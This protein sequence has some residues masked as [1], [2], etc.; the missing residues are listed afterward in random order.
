MATYIKGHKNF[1]PDIKPFTPDYKFL[2]A[3]LDATQAKYDA[4]WK[5]QNDLYNKVVYSP[6]TNPNSLEYQRQ[7]AEKLGPSLE[8]ITG[9]D[10][11]LE[12]N[13][14]AAKSAFAPFFED[15]EVVYDM[16]WTGAYN[17]AVNKFSSL[18]SSSNEETRQLANI[19]VGMGKLDIDR[20]K[21][22]EAGRGELRN[23]P[24]PELILD[25][26]LVRN[27]QK[28]LS[29][30]DPGLTISMPVPNL[31]NSGK[32]DASGNPILVEDDQFIITQ[33]NGNL[34]EGAA[35]E[36]I[37]TALYDDPR[38]QKF[39][40]AKSYVQAHNTAA[41]LVESGLAPSEQAGLNMW[42]KEQVSRLEE[43]NLEYQSKKEYDLRKQTQVNV[44]WDNYS[45]NH[46]VVVGSTD[47][48]TM[49]ANLSDAEKIKIDLDRLFKQNQFAQSD[50][51]DEGAL[52]NKAM[53]MLSNYNM[54]KDMRTAAR[55][56]SLREMEIT[57]EVNPYALERLE[58]RNK[59]NLQI[60]KFKLQ[61]IENM[62]RDKKQFEYDKE[63]KS[64]EGGSSGSFTNQQRTGVFNDGN[65]SA[66]F[67][68][69]KDNKLLFTDDPTAYDAFEMDKTKLKLTRERLGM[70]PEMLKNSGLYNVE[71]QVGMYKIPLVTNPNPDNEDDYFI[72]NLDR[73]LDKL[74]NPTVVDELATDNFQYQE[75]IVSLFANLQEY[76]QDPTAAFKANPNNKEPNSEY[77]KITKKLFSSGSSIELPG[78]AT[79]I[80]LNDTAIKLAFEDIYTKGR[81]V[82]SAFNNTAEKDLSK[83]QQNITELLKYNYTVPFNEEDKS[84]MTEED[85]YEANKALVDSKQ[86][87]VNAEPSLWGVQNFNLITTESV[88]KTVEELNFYPIG[89]EYNNTMKTVEAFDD[90]VFKRNLKMIY[91]YYYDNINT[92]RS[93]TNSKTYTNQMAGVFGPASNIRFDKTMSSTVNLNP[94]AG[95]EQD[96]LLGNFYSQ[97]NT[98][99]TSGLAGFI[100]QTTAELDQDDILNISGDALD[101][102][103][104]KSKAAKFIYDRLNTMNAVDK[105]LAME[106]T[107]FNSWGATIVD[108]K[109]RS[110]T[111]TPK[112]AYQ[113]S[114]FSDAFIK[115]ILSDDITVVRP[116][117]VSA[118]EINKVLREGFTY[119]FPR[120]NT[121]NSNPLSYANAASN[122][123]LEKRINNSEN[124]VYTI[125]PNA[126]AAPYFLD[127]SGTGSVDFEKVGNSIVA[128]GYFNYYESDAEKY[129]TGYRREPFSIPFG[130]DGEGKT[131]YDTMYDQIITTLTNIQTSN[132]AQYTA[133]SN[134]AKGVNTEVV[135]N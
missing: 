65:T 113:L 97:V 4:G 111:N 126:F 90:K 50:D 60:E 28:Y 121:V 83:D 63:L 131:D 76:Y 122:S 70:L 95:S 102:T 66:S 56:F 12:Q 40:N 129:P 57:Q 135:T 8:K 125:K 39:Y 17:E 25:A 9:L 55:Q 20:R 2:S 62:R 48:I 41:G 75:G 29:A 101:I 61:A 44:N 6:L 26:D 130:G 108:P 73:V 34:I 74:N 114:N 71:G 32:V 91:D 42:A 47:E 106:L 119:I 107:F 16:V 30:L 128:T 81:T 33:K 86:I 92:L 88:P 22:M 133:K 1:Y 18:A 7:Y 24:L 79:Q 112:A 117:G 115:S 87:D 21:F 123:T 49:R 77:A 78:L 67:T 13:V 124:N 120:D 51:I 110:I 104:D 85:F 15:E 109:T 14:Q 27:A 98:S 118:E 82:Q 35:Y 94:I 31:K 11:S 3:T 58:N 23:Q 52:M 10:L 72:G 105:A 59:R 127:N 43:K 134:E 36:Q 19:E 69:N 100:G 54:D 103:N 53:A 132:Q 116:E 96:L 37:M 46:G 64:M 38:V 68:V 93:N 5:A 45:N 99:G 84:F 80:E 89:K